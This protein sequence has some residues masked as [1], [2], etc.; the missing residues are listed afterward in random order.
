[1]DDISIVELYC[2]RRE[3]AIRETQNKYGGAFFSVSYGVLRIKEDAEECVNDTYVKLWGAIPP[4][5][6][7]NLG[8]YGCRVA[9]NT[10]IDRLRG[11]TAEKRR[12]AED[13]H[14]ELEECVPGTD[15]T[16]EVV[17]R[18]ALSRAISVFLSSERPERRIMFM[19]RYFYMETSR[20]IAK[21]LH[22]PDATV[23]ATL[24][25]MRKRLREFLEKEGITV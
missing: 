25:R 9:R 5:K 1:M 21:L 12:H 16:A 8:A 23:R 3:S 15:E 4:D 14:A 24:K 22:I 11:Y 20:D 18:I 13:I 6:P 10:A 2:Q 19:R 7:G 17:D